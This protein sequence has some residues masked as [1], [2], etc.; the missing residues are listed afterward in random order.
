MGKKIVVLFPGVRGTEIPLLYFCGKVFEDR[1]YEKLFIQPPADKPIGF[2]SLFK[3]AVS[4]LEPL[5]LSEYDSVVFVA[6]SMGTVVAGTVKEQFGI[7]AALVFLT[8]LE[9][10]FRFIRKGNDVLFVAMGSEDKH[11][12]FEAVQSLCAKEKINFYVEHGV[13]HRMEGKEDIH[14]DLLVIENVVNAL[15]SCLQE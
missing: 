10:T 5:H 7:P 13:G 1:G 15:T 6:K 12:D 2:E 14:R 11:T 4:V 8:P 3:S 9:E